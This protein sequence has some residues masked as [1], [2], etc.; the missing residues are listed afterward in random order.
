MATFKLFDDFGEDL[1]KEIHTLATDD[2]EVLL[3]NVAPVQ[4]TGSVYTDITQIA[5]GNGYTQ[6][7]GA[8]SPHQLTGLTWS[9]TGAGLGVWR[10]LSA[11][12]VFTAAGGSIAQFR[13]PV[14]INNTAPSNEVVGYLDYG[15][16]VDVTVGNTFTLDVGA[17]GW[18]ELT[19]P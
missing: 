7:S 2:F 14:I 15:G 10:W 13:Y 1:G 16:P 8:N 19:I 3:S 5:T 4:D 12:F 11:D 6:F 17:N 9:E 18:F